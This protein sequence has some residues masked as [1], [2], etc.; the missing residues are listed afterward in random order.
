MAVIFFQINTQ[1]PFLVL[2]TADLVGKTLLAWSH[3]GCA[4]YI[5]HLSG[6]FSY[7]PHDTIQIL[8]LSVDG[9]LGP[10]GLGMELFSGEH[11]PWGK[12]HCP[13]GLQFNMTGTDQ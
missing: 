4:L 2:S 1:V 10:S 13:A 7:F 3:Q 5:F 12:D 8:I 11:S 9:V 6:L